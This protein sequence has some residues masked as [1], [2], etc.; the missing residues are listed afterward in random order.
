VTGGGMK[1]KPLYIKRQGWEPIPEKYKANKSMRT[2][3]MKEHN[4][5]DTT[6]T[7]IK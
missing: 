5:Q 3:V 7:L 6:N 1:E 4:N 2:Y